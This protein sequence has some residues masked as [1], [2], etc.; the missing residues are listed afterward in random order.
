M[1][2]FSVTMRIVVSGAEVDFASKEEELKLWFKSSSGLSS[3]VEV[4]LGFEA[5][6]G[7]RRL[8]AA[9]EI[10]MTAQ[11]A[12]LDEANSATQALSDTVGNTASSATAAL[13]SLGIT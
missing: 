2:G 9:T 3:E 12:T 5:A 11:V 6:Q 4:A 13:S 8:S 1:G 10:T 7:R